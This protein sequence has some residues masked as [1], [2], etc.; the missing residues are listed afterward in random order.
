MKKEFTSDTIESVLDGQITVIRDRIY[1]SGFRTPLHVPFS[2]RTNCA[3]GEPL[4]ILEKEHEDQARFNAIGSRLLGSSG[5]H[6]PVLDIDGGAEVRNSDKAIIYA[7]YQG[8]F[9]PESDI[10][11]L[12]GDNKISVTI[13][14][15]PPYLDD[16]SHFTPKITPGGVR[17]LV[18]RSPRPIFET[19]DS[20]SKGHS[21]LY[22]QQ[23][24]NDWDHRTLIKELGK[25]GIVAPA[26]QA[27]TEQEGMSIVRT[28]WTE[29][30]IT[31]FPS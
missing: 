27:M 7:A 11:D 31:H 4:N 16:S 14:E 21:H 8:Y 15:R 17:A 22:I 3:P 10:E 26:W 13:F 28:P 2:S 23:E 6:K 18:L 30:E 19:A 5:I 12:L 9:G 1:S 25:L 20:T 29:K 24:F